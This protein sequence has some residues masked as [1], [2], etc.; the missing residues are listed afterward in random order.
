MLMEF[1]RKIPKYWRDSQQRIKHRSWKTFPARNSMNEE[2]VNTQ[3]R[4]SI[5]EALFYLIIDDELLIA[6]L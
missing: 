1:P 2:T 5:I 3:K 4:A 6:F